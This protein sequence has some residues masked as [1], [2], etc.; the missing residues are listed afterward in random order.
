MSYNAVTS[1]VTLVA[2]MAR[3]MAQD[4]VKSQVILVRPNRLKDTAMYD[5]FRKAYLEVEMDGVKPKLIETTLLEFKK[6]MRS[7]QTNRIV[8][9]T[10]AKGDANKLVN[11]I[12][13]TTVKWDDMDV[14]IYA[15]ND[16]VDF[17]NIS[18]KYKN[19]FQLHYASPYLLD[20]D[21]ERMKMV[22]RQYRQKYNADM[23]KMA[24]QGFDVTMHFCMSMLMRQD[25]LPGLM[26][27]IKMI[28][29]GSNNGYENVNGYF[30]KFVDYNLVKV[31][32]FND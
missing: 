12:N 32:Q 19:K 20:Y 22:H 10:N 24:T 27:E 2:S 29:K 8:F 15:T 28:Q 13:K 26:N 3:F 16:W 7:G 4:T 23:S 21:N 30:M 9:L 5:A 18:S 1:E 14:R 6:F 31:T 25:P 17:E 11:E